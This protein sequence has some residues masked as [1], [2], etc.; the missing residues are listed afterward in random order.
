ML[1]TLEFE[2]IE[3]EKAPKDD[4]SLSLSLSLCA[5]SRRR[6]QRGSACVGA[7]AARE[8]DDGEN[9]AG[10]GGWPGKRWVGRNRLGLQ[11]G[12]GVPMFLPICLLTYL[13]SRGFYENWRH[14]TRRRCF[15]GDDRGEYSR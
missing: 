8:R 6:R 15:R 7:A 13:T 11:K 3:T 9:K 10:P 12:S 5:T 2:R 1:N 14:E 4:S